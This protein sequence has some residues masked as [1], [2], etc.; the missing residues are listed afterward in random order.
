M[1]LA[2]SCRG[3]LDGAF[4]RRQQRNERIIAAVPGTFISIELRMIRK[5]AS[6]L[7]PYLSENL[8]NDLAV[9]IVTLPLVGLILAFL[10]QDAGQMDA[11]GVQFW[12]VPSTS[13]VMP[14]R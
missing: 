14:P 1:P 2:V 7:N 4:Y 12:P 6:L 11:P 5:L 8:C 9:L 13:L 10:S 3:S